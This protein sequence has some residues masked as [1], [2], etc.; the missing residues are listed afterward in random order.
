MNYEKMAATAKRLI[1]SNGAKCVLRNP[2]GNLPVYNPATNDY[3][4]DKTSFDGFCIVSGYEDRVVDGTVIQVGDRKIIA[5]LTGEP[6]PKL[7]TLDVFNKA[8][9]LQDSYK[10]IN[11]RESLKF[12]GYSPLEIIK[13]GFIQ[14]CIIFLFVCRNHEFS[15]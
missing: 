9:K 14:K 1:G 10:V 4:A 2:S 13:K 15:C 5:V 8:G 6:K 12:T 3:E 11:W 7:S